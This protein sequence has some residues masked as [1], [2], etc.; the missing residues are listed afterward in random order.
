MYGGGG[1]FGEGDFD[2]G[3]VICGEIAD[4]FAEF[5]CA[6]ELRVCVD[7]ADFRKSASG[8]AAGGVA[9]EEKI[10]ADEINF[11]VAE[12]HDVDTSVPAAGV[13][14]SPFEAEGV[15]R[16]VEDFCLD[17]EFAVNEIQRAGSGG[18]A[19]AV[20]VGV[21]F[22]AV[23]EE[24]VVVIKRVSGAATSGTT[25]ASKKQGEVSKS[26]MTIADQKV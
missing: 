6:R 16:R 25:I 7:D 2:L 21:V 1:K 9:P 3:P 14:G 18:V 4:E 10:A 26:L 19:G 22:E 8:D 24:D 13:C 20:E 23:V 11:A 15:G 17:G 5:Q 12:T